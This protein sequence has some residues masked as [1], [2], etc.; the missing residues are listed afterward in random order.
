MG[1][2]PTLALMKF[3]RVDT[4]PPYVFSEVN[5]RGLE[6]RRSG[7]DVIDLG[8]GNPDIPSLTFALHLLDHGQ[9]TVS[10]G[11]GFGPS[12][13]GHVCFAL[14]ENDQRIG[15]AVRGIRKA[16]DRL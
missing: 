12:G 15:Q 5:R 10:P 14:V 4:L 9:V 11:I 7:V 2:P 13:E 3:R 16:L 1:T 8:F 6:A